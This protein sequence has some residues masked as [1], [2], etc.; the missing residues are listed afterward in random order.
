MTEEETAIATWTMVSRFD[1][2]IM[3]EEMTLACW[4]G[5]VGHWEQQVRIAALKRAREALASRSDKSRAHA[6]IAG[7]G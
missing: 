7:E 1:D 4:A 5:Q 3:I 6:A 2:L